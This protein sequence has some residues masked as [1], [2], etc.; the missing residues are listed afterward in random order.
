[1]TIE[2][3]GV[4]EAERAIRLY[5]RFGFELAGLQPKEAQIEPGESVDAILMYRWLASNR[6]ATPRG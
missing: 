3:P 2:R 1:M 6:L 4:E 5:E